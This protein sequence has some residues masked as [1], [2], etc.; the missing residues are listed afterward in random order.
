MDLG[1]KGIDKLPL[2]EEIVIY[3]SLGQPESLGEG[4]EASKTRSSW[5]HSVQQGVWDLFEVKWEATV[6]F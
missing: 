5:T 6:D 4:G 3:L 1:Q 2:E